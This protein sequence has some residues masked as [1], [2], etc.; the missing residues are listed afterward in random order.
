[1]AWFTLDSRVFCFFLNTSLPLPV[2]LETGEKIFKDEDIFKE[3]LGS[4]D[5][6]AALS[7]PCPSSL[8]FSPD[9]FNNLG[10]Q[11]EQAWPKFDG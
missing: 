11:V 4:L 7:L 8:T 1:M 2:L 5:L 10:Q 3:A 9:P 6:S